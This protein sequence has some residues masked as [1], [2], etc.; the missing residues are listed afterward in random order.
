MRAS[1]RSSSGGHSMNFHNIQ[2]WKTYFKDTGIRAELMDLYL[3]FI[4]QCLSKKVPPIFEQNHLAHLVGREPNILMA[5]TFGTESYYRE[6]KLKKRSGGMRSIRAPYPSLLEVQKWI[7]EAILK[8][9]TLPNCVTGF[10]EGYS[11]LDN[12]KMHCKRDEVLK[13]D[14]KD[15]FPSIGF[16][17]VMKV[18]LGFGYPLNVAFTLSRLCTL[19]DQLPQ[20]AA[21]S[22]SL[23]NVICAD[24]D[25]RFVKLCK[26]KRLRYTRYADDIT[27]SGKK[28]PEGIKRL[29][30]EIIHSEGFTVNEKKV[31]FLSKNDRKIVTGLDITTGKPRVTRKFR[32]EIQQDIYFVWSAGLSSHVARRKIFA[33]HYVQQLQGRV[34]F[35]ASIEPENRQLKRTKKRLERITGIYGG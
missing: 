5:M 9:V 28:I 13:I 20:G 6:F 8:S 24:M 22:P 12:A 3:P 31:R 1:K 2:S 7:N 35:W 18:F 19:D 4:K 32:R 16:S 14:L 23:S 29:F 17:R 34:Q 26:T 11:I 10:R 30:F 21:T 33:P 15:F 25:R 27:I